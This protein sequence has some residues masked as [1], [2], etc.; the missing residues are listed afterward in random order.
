[1]KKKLILSL[2]LLVMG[3]FFFNSCRTDET[4]QEEKR[5]EREKIGAFARFEENLASKSLLQKDGSEYVSYHE[6]FMKTIQ[7]F[8][9]KNPDYSKKFHDQVGDVYFDLR[10]FTYGEANKGIVYPIMKDGKVNAALFGIINLERDWVNFSVLKNDSPEVQSILS[11]FQKQYDL[12]QQS[13]AREPMH[14]MAIEEVVITIYESIPG[15]SYIFYNPYADYGSSGGAGGLGGGMS[16]GGIIH[17]GGGNPQPENPKNPCEKTKS[18]FNKPN[19]KQ[20][21]DNV[22]ANAKLT[23]TD[24]NAGEIGFK[25]KKDGTVVPADVNSA[26]QVVFNDVTDSN[27]GYHN[28]TENGIHMI[29]PQDMTNSL[30]GFASAQSI[31]DG[32]GNAY[33]GMIAAEP[34]STCPDGIKYVHYIVHYAGTA[35]ELGG[36]VYSPAQIKKFESK[37]AETA[38]DLSEPILN[39]N[40]YINSSGKLNEKGLEKLFF[41][42]LTSM[43][44]DDKVVLQRVEANGT[45]YNVTKNSSGIITA[46]PCP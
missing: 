43:G 44:L 21:I 6:P 8:M 30:F 42:T 24:P 13:K 25:E 38:T 27:G 31:N 34:C 11:K 22:K 39:G 45:V 1:M 19:I 3:V 40:T 29:A 4:A 41:D 46:T 23:L 35:T 20:G 32:V 18:M 14:E 28:H 17:G 33:L 7:T 10:S 12:N 37:Y 2:L 36:F 26:H 5:T 9:D 15:P 16:G